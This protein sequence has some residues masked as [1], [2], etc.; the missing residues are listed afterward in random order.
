MLTKTQR[1]DMNYPVTPYRKW[2]SWE[3]GTMFIVDGI[4]KCEVLG[5]SS[6]S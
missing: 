4:V 2:K 1:K 5:S 6:R 3:I